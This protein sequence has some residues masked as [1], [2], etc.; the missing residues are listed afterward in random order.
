LIPHYSLL[1]FFQISI[2]PYPYPLECT[3]PDSSVECIRYGRPSVA[4][5]FHWSF[6]GILIFALCYVSVTMFM[7]YRSVSKIEIQAHRYSFA[8]YRSQRNN[9]MRSRRVMLQG[10]LYSLALFCVNIFVLIEMLDKS[11]ISHTLITLSYAFWPLQGFFNALIFSIPKFQK[12][13]K[14]WKERQ[15]AILKLQEAGK[16]ESSTSADIHCQLSKN[17]EKKEETISEIFKSNKM[18]NDNSSS[19]EKSLMHNDQHLQSAIMIDEEIEEEGRNREFDSEEVKEEIKKYNESNI[20]NNIKISSGDRHIDNDVCN[21]E[22]TEE[23]NQLDQSTYAF[24]HHYEYESCQ[25]EEYSESNVE[26]ILN[27]DDND[28]DDDYIFLSSRR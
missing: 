16:D 7:V 8:I 3:D 14:N 26:L 24:R 28:S 15:I 21:E 11:N 23:N 10:V 25:S 22:V 17:R 1:A 19:N 12:L 9:R 6:A 2:S 13:Y 20:I 4:K 5:I 18:S 27:D